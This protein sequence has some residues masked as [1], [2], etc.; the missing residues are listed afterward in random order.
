M[1]WTPRSWDQGLEPHVG[2]LV[3]L[4]GA[5]LC[6]AGTLL[7]PAMAA[8]YQLAWWAQLLQL[9]FWAG[10]CGATI[11][12]VHR[13]R[14][15]LL[16]AGLTATSFLVA[17]AV[18]PWTTAPGVTAAWVVELLCAIAFVVIVGWAWR[19]SDPR[20]QGS[21]PTPAPRPALVSLRGGRATSR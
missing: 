16:G 5:G 17:A 3:V 19:V 13:R 14:A 2:G 11:A 8:R 20:V 15:A 21:S 12:V 7:E 1:A 6:T 18:V 9:L 4:A 10:A